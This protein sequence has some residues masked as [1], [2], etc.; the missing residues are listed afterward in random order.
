MP[1]AEDGRGAAAAELYNS[2]STGHALAP[3]LAEAPIL[4]QQQ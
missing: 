2:K 4:T 3:L 1:G